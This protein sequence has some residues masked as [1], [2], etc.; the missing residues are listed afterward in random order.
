MRIALGVMGLAV[1][2]HRTQEPILIGEPSG[3]R[4]M[5]WVDDRGRVVLGPMRLARTT[6]RRMLGIG[7]DGGRWHSLQLSVSTEQSVL[8]FDR[9]PVP[10]VAVNAQPVRFL[11]QLLSIQESEPAVGLHLDAYSDGAL[12]VDASGR[13]T[14]VNRAATEILGL[15]RT[16]HIGGPVRSVFDRPADRALVARVDA[17]RR[18]RT[19]TRLNEPWSAPNGT[20]YDVHVAPAVGG[21]V[22]LFH[23][24]T[25]RERALVELRRAQVQS[26]KRTRELRWLVHSAE[27]F[28][29]LEPHERLDELIV[30]QTM[31]LL[32]ESPL[33]AMLEVDANG[34]LAVCRKVGT[35]AE[36]FEWHPGPMSPE[37]AS[38]LQAGHAI[39]GSHPGR[40]VGAELG[41]GP[42]G[43]E[44]SSP[45]TW[46]VLGLSWEESVPA[47]VVACV[48]QE[49][50]PSEILLDGF[51]VQASE[52]LA[53]RKARERMDEA[54]ERL[55]SLQRMDALSRLTSGLAH[56]LNNLLAVIQ[57]NLGL[58]AEMPPAHPDAAES[59]SHMEGAALR[60][61]R[62]TQ[63]LLLVGR[64]RI[65]EP[66]PVRVAEVVDA[67]RGVLE[68]LLVPGT[69]LR[70]EGIEDPLWALGDADGLQNALMNM[71]L[72]AVQ[73]MPDGGVVSISARK[74]QVAE[75]QVDGLKP[76][77]YAVI[78]VR[79]TGEGM[80]E[81]VRQR[82]FDPF[83]TTRADGSGLGLAAAYGFVKQLGGTIEVSSGR[84][85]GTTFRIF[86]P[87][88]LPVVDQEASV[89]P[90]G[91]EVLVVEDDP[92]LLRFVTRIL[93]RR[94]LRAH[95]YAHAASALAAVDEGLRFDVV[96]TD[97]MMPGQNGVRLVQELE[98]RSMPRPVVF[99]TGYADAATLRHGLDRQAARVVEKPFTAQELFDAIGSCLALG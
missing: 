53:R 12:R 65:R 30:R 28:L 24:A 76:G 60:A 55:Q 4:S 8:L 44:S 64:N 97:V 26:A 49:R 67:I 14:F 81:E 38:V 1:A 42:V 96:V 95:A 23:D 39:I 16:Q 47:V 7:E 17:A 68:A 70:I 18:H 66:E 61:A 29:A 57:G 21:V 31:L 40:L 69:S 27:A 79:D 15:A 22:L 83:F 41:D 98:K 84:G 25:E 80:P 90:S 50:L 73:A 46:I 71:V 34:D 45:H 63:Q 86:L 36:D 82:V 54:Q 87:Q 20:P 62:L 78:E 85:K 6:S 19:A 43:R 59:I 89:I 13:V 91:L 5:R 99:I 33:V 74:G 10:P 75:G 35:M 93:Q 72:N 58:L 51:V 52:A 11:R 94:G 56:D 2:G 48:E 77:H 88:V 37:A 9:V 3:W 32:G 92:A